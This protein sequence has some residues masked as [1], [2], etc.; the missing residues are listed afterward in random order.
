M[1]YNTGT[2]LAISIQMDVN[3]IGAWRWDI[4]A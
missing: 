2:Y 3:I 4:P 1:V